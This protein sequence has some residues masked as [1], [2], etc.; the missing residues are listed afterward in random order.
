MGS[1][2]FRFF[3]LKLF[4]MKNTSLSV[5][6]LILIA[7]ST[8][9]DAFGQRKTGRSKNVDIY[10]GTAIKK[11]VGKSMDQLLVSNA[12]G[13]VMHGFFNQQ[14]IYTAY[15]TT[16]QPV[17][18]NKIDRLQSDEAFVRKGFIRLKEKAV[19]LTGQTLH[20]DKANVV[21]LSAFDAENLTT[22]K[23]VEVSRVSGNGFH[24]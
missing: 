24:Q 14:D 18:D 11:T 8:L 9:P 15:D 2:E 6:L 13:F 5:F 19:L 22:E 4:L 7:F 21:Y 16:L 12:N 20:Y 23:P 3:A 10:M 17:S 1:H